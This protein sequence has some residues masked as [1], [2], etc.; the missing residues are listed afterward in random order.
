M[1]NQSNV[2]DWRQ[3]RFADST[4]TQGTDTL[5]LRI[6]DNVDLPTAL[7]R[8]CITNLMLRI[9][10]NVDLPTAMLV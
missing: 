4:A 6:G 5:M 7:R 8:V 10:D 2:A 9:G 3:R 1:Y